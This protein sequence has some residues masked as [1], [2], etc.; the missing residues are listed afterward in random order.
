MSESR[1]MQAVCPT[2]QHV[3]RNV[4]ALVLIAI[5]ISSAIAAIVVLSDELRLNATIPFFSGFATVKFSVALSLLLCNLSLLV[6]ISDLRHRWMKRFAIAAP[7][8]VAGTIAGGA[9]LY[10]FFKID[11]GIEPLLHPDGLIADAAARMGPTNATCIICIILAIVFLYRMPGLSQLFSIISF[12][13]AAMAVVAYMYGGPSLQS[14]PNYPSMKL[15]SA[16]A[17]GSLSLAIILLTPKVGLARMIVSN[18][19]GGATVRRLFPAVI[20]V[21]PTLGWINLQAHLR[22]YSEM[23]MSTVLISTTSTV[24]LM[25]LVYYSAAVLERGDVFRR[26]VE[27]DR[28][29]LLTR[30]RAARQGAERALH[31]RDQLL[32]IVSHE[33]RTPLTPILLTV[34]SLQNRD[35]LSQ[36]LREDLGMIGEQVQ[37]ESKMVGDLLDLVSLTQGKASL[38]RAPVDLN[39]LTGNTIRQ[40]DALFAQ[41]KIT[42]RIHLAAQ[43]H[44][45]LGDVSR[46][47]QIISSLLSNALKFTPSGGSV[48]I[49]SRDSSDN[50]IELEVGDT[51][52]GIEPAFMARMFDAFEQREISLSRHFGG[53][54]VGLTIC[55][56]LIDLHEGSIRPNSD[57]LGKGSTFT[58]TLPTTIVADHRDISSQDTDSPAENLRVL[59]VEDDLLMARALEA[60]LRTLGHG[61]R[62]AGSGAEALRLLGERNFDLILC[63]IG[64]PDMTGWHFLKQLS[65]SRAIPAIAFSG[66]TSP[67]DRQRSLEAGFCEHLAKPIVIPELIKALRIA[68]SQPNRVPSVVD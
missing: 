26:A 15:Y 66:Y 7:A 44:T 63:D 10:R 58:L 46:L 56:M 50:Q 1:G 28:D 53:L 52:I 9:L 31:A 12:T 20:L 36:E 33:L 45:V 67:E 55:K 19:P 68:R 42:L 41:K 64:L 8:A 65:P 40:F 23:T 29:D 34:S 54:G 6:K 4:R 27:A 59:L 49:R 30:E 57:G 61:G 25:I 62:V 2:N 3:L 5:F 24:V 39:L 18:S 13:P 35:D 47:G 48:T 16:I 21:P 32:S 43:S 17:S 60:M 11:L 22:G 37:T 14:V 38:L 51:G